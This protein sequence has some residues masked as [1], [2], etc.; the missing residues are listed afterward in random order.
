MFDGLQVERDLR[1]RVR[2]LS[3]DRLLIVVAGLAVRARPF[4]RRFVQQYPE[5]AYAGELLDESLARVWAAGGTQLPGAAELGRRL[6][7]STPRGTDGIVLAIPGAL[8]GFLPLYCLADQLDPGEDDSLETIVDFVS[9]MVSQRYNWYFMDQGQ[10]LAGAEDALERQGGNEASAHELAVLARQVA[11][12]ASEP[13]T[14]GLREKCREDSEREG[15][16][17]LGIVDGWEAAAGPPNWALHELPPSEYGVDS[18][19]AMLVRRTSATRAFLSKTIEALPPEQRSVAARST[20]RR[21]GYLGEVL[22]T[23]EAFGL[24]DR[25][26]VRCGNL[27][28]DPESE[29]DVTRLVDNPGAVHEYR[30]VER[31]LNWLESE[32]LTD[33]LVERLIA[34]SDR[35]GRWLATIVSHWV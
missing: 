25:L 3:E 5:W 6:R 20:V 27:L 23:A 13:F 22:D 2:A 24:L 19:G 9:E 1:E 10:G 16:A 8:E 17:L 32:P 31:Q 34:D 11:W 30:V 33:D 14:S 12:L 28:G 4:H 18:W 35:E 21:A 29:W 7:E 26:W 15:Q